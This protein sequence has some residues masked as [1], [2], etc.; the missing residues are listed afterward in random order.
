MPDLGYRSIEVA[1]TNDTRGNLTVQGVVAGSGSSWVQGETP[2]QG[3][4]LPQYQAVKWGVDTND[5]DGIANGQVSLTGLGS[6]PVSLVVMNDFTGRSACNVTGND[7][8]SAIVTQVQ[9]GEVNHS[10]FVV[11]LIPAVSAV[12]AAPAA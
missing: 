7:S 6:Y 4:S 5:V 10:Q 9:T 11:Q 2:N 8:V 1:V 3:D 12:A